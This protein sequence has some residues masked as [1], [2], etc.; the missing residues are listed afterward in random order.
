ME[1]PIYIQTYAPRC[2]HCGE[3]LTVGSTAHLDDNDEY[4]C[5][6]C[7]ESYLEKFSEEREAEVEACEEWS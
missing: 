6:S 3:E 5:D 4:L 2:S 1:R 7:W